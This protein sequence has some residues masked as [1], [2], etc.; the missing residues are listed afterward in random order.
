MRKAKPASVPPLQSSQPEFW[1]GPD[2]TDATVWHENETSFRRKPA[3]GGAALPRR[4]QNTAAKVLPHSPTA[5][6]RRGEGPSPSKAPS[7]VARAIYI[8]Q[9]QDKFLEKAREALNRMQE[10][11]I[12]SQQTVPAHRQLCLEE[13][14]TLISFLE[15]L[16]ETEIDG[17]KLF[18]SSNLI[19]N[20]PGKS[21]KL[22]LPAVDLG[23]LAFRSALAL[24]IADSESAGKALGVLQDTLRFISISRSMIAGNLG[25]LAFINSRAEHAKQALFPTAHKKQVKR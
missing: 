22:V 23:H 6:E 5:A 4:H 14:E 1:S 12:L 20:L 15:Q 9:A 16:A 13:F 18:R 17:V 25:R 19:L 11:A 3:P 2:A 7:E 24:S 21:D 10:L 8:L